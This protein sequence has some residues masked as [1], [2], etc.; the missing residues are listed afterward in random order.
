MNRKISKPHQHRH[1]RR[2]PEPP[3]RSRHHRRQNLHSQLSIPL[4]HR[5]QQHQIKKVQQPNPNNPKHQMQPPQHNRLVRR[6]TRQKRKMRPPLRKRKHKHTEKHRAPRLL[7]TRTP[8]HG[9][10]TGG[11]KMEFFASAVA[12][13]KHQTAHTNRNQAS[14]T[15]GLGAFASWLVYANG[16]A[17][18][19]SHSIICLESGGGVFSLPTS[20]ESY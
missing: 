10:E 11:H 3:H 2:R 12:C 19:E 17:L 6:P 9:I 18:R 16:N 7:R 5:R 14:P 1:Q 20:L 15:A 13:A 4:L 8:H